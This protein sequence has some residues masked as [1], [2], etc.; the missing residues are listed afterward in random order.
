MSAAT[1]TATATAAPTPARTAAPHRAA[2]NDAGSSV[3]DLPSPSPRNDAPLRSA[4]V[5]F[6]VG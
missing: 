5:T 3:D 2:V 6:S 4:A 1:A